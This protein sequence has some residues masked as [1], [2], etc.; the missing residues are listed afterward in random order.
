MIRFD[1]YTATAGGID[2]GFMVDLLLSHKCSGDQIVNGHGYHGFERR[3][4]L[5]D[6]SGDA[7][8]SV[9]WG[10]DRVAG[11]VLF[12]VKGERTPEYVSTLR[13]KVR[14][15]RC[16]R[17][18]ACADFD[19][20]GIFDRLVGQMEVVKAAFRLYGE[21]RGDWD[22]HPELGRT[23]YLGAPSSAVRARCY[24]KGRQPEYRFLNRPDWVRLEVQVRP[25]KEG[26]EAFAELSASQVWGAS[27][28]TREL[29]A[30]ALAE[31]V[32]PHPAGTVYRLSE[33]QTALRWML[34][35]YGPHL[36]AEARDLGGWDVLG[37]TLRQMLDDQQAEKQAQR[38]TRG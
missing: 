12:E 23:F 10:G 37:L 25:Q 34:R 6:E 32:D 22:D 33:R 35:Q 4:A 9:L 17:V 30:R 13:E 28:W 1:A 26:R 3:A 21:R 2:H 8:A 38:D 19:E 36:A 7:V 14:S 27:P 24:E 18:D 15:H 31:H 16:T 20:E 11:R 5:V 29:A